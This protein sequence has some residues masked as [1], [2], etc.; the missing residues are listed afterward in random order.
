MF[1]LHF[2]YHE[3]KVKLTLS[4]HYRL[5]IPRRQASRE[6]VIRRLLD[7]ATEGNHTNGYQVDGV[8]HPGRETVPADVAHCY[9]QHRC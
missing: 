4:S 2:N 9:E 7:R 3:K 5:C 8:R 1:Q 6:A